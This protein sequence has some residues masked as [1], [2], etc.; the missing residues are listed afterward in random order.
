MKIEV[1]PCLFLLVVQLLYPYCRSSES[2]G[3]IIFMILRPDLVWENLFRIWSLHLAVWQ[4]VLKPLE[5][6]LITEPRLCFDG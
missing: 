4:V 5:S 6:P 3:R 1:I 2:G